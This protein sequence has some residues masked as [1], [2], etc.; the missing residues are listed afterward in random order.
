[1]ASDS[2]TKQHIPDVGTD[3]YNIRSGYLASS[4]AN[5]CVVILVLF[6]DSQNIFIEHRLSWSEDGSKDAMRNCLFYVASHVNSSVSQDST[7]S[8]VTFN[9]SS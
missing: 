1:M 2:A 8:L 4:G 7:I 9:K 3:K 5:T 6:N